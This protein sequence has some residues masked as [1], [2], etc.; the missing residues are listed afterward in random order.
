MPLSRHTKPQ[1][2]QRAI[3]KV[4]RLNGLVE[5]VEDSEGNI[6]FKSSFDGKVFDE[7][8]QAVGHVEATGINT[9]RVFGETNQ[10]GSKKGLEQIAEES[11]QLSKKLRIGNISAIQKEALEKLGL[12]FLIGQ[13]IDITY[14]KFNYG[15]QEQRL[16][17]IAKSKFVRDAGIVN[18]TDEG[19]TVLNYRVG[20]RV[21]QA[22][23]AKNM[24]YI[25]G[26][27][28][29]TDEFASKVLGSGGAPDF[30]GFAKLPK[31]IQG[32]L[33]EREISITG[34]A[35]QDV[36]SSTYE[37]DD[38]SAFFRGL[39]RGDTTEAEKYLISSGMGFNDK[40]RRTVSLGRD[41]LS[42]ERGLEKKFSEIAGFESLSLD[43]KN[44]LLTKMR[45]LFSTEAGGDFKQFKTIIE[46][47]I[48]SGVSSDIDVETLRKIQASF[49][50]V[51]K[52][53]DGEFVANVKMVD[54]F[55]ETLQNQKESIISSS[56][57][58]GP[59]EMKQ[60]SEIDSQLEGLLY[61]KESGQEGLDS[62][63]ARIQ[64][65]GQQGKGEM[66]LRKF[67]GLPKELRDKLLIMPQSA[68]KK[69]VA[70]VPSILLN[71]S[72][73]HAE[74]VYADPLM[75]LYHQ[76]YFNQDT[77]LKGAVNNVDKQ[78][79]SI[80]SFLETGALPDDVKK[81][82]FG[83]IDSELKENPAIVAKMDAAAKASYIRNRSEAKAIQEAI[84]A[85]EDPRNI[86]AL[87][88]RITDHY[89][90]NAFRIKQSPRGDRVDL[91]MPDTMR[92]S[93]RTYE[94]SLESG[95]G[96]RL[97]Q[98]ARVNLASLGPEGMKYSQLMGGATEDTLNLMQFRIQGNRM[99]F[100]GP[101][102]HLYH[103][104]LGTF[105]L[106]D[107]G[108][109]LMTTFKDAKGNDRLAF[110]AMRQPT[111][112]QEKIFMQGD[113]TDT[114]TLRTILQKSSGDFSSLLNDA[115]AVSSLSDPKE[116]RILNLMRQ[117]VNEKG[118]LDTAGL[119]SEEIENVLVKLRNGFGSK[120]GFQDLVKIT[121]RDIL[122]MVTTKSSSAL[123]LD[124]VV[125]TGIKG[126]TKLQDFTDFLAERG[127]SPDSMPGYT[128]GNFVSMLAEEQAKSDETGL[129]RQFN[130]KQG[131]SFTNTDEIRSYISSLS[132]A[133]KLAADTNFKTILQTMAE[134]TQLSS[135]RNVEDSLGLY[136]NRQAA[137]ISMSGQVDD[138]LESLSGSFSGMTL[139]AQIK[140]VA[141]NVSLEDYFRLNF[142][143]AIIPPSEAVDIS[144]SLVGEMVM[145][146][147]EMRALAIAADQL[148]GSGA[149]SESVVESMI[150][151]QA[152]RAVKLGEAG[153]EVIQQTGRGVGF[154]RAMQIA[155]GVS[156]D[157]LIGFD[158]VIFGEGVNARIRKKDMLSTIDSVVQG[159]Q[160]Y[161]S[162]ITDNTERGLVQAF[163]DDVS[164]SSVE[165]AIAKVSLEAGSR[166]AVLQS[167]TQAAERSRES[168]DS[169]A[170]YAKRLARTGSD[171][172]E[173]FAIAEYMDSAEALVE[174][175]KSSI[176][177]LIDIANSFGDEI[178][179]DVLRNIQA[180]KISG[181]L[182]MGLSAAVE[183]NPSKN[184]LDAF[185][186]LES[187][188]KVQYG[189]RIADKVLSAET[190]IVGMEDAL[191]KIRED[192]RARRINSRTIRRVS[193]EAYQGI[194][195]L[196]SGEGFSGIEFTDITKQQASEYVRYVNEAQAAAQRMEGMTAEEFFSSRSSQDLYDFMR[197]R[198]GQANVFM[199]SDA[200][201]QEAVDVFSAVRAREEIEAINARTTSDYAVSGSNISDDARR[202]VSEANSA[203]DVTSVAKT[204]YTRIQDFIKNGSLREL[205]DDKLIK[206]S[207]LAM[208]GLAAFGFVYSARKERTQDEMTG[209]PLLPGGSAYETDFPRQVP[210]ISDLKYLNP[211]TLGMQ[212]KINVSGSQQDIEKMQYLASGVVGGNVDS[213]IYN[214]LPRLGRDPYSEVASRF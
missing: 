214:S 69:E 95:E 90:G 43:D 33:S 25:L 97:Y 31:R 124:K 98:S 145:K 41:N 116:L 36:L 46:Q 179:G 64:F 140:G 32:V 6:K 72:K 99:M 68:M 210:T 188:I 92:K 213:T 48:E 122:E 199:D 135:A 193:D 161:L 40:L 100:S 14:Q 186:T 134:S 178:Q 77:F 207:T 110:M 11:S 143:A 26:L 158:P 28:T 96:A 151:R 174:S 175:Q 1:L 182:F 104:S 183:G 154:L 208:A 138:V 20:K 51:E 180:P 126:A 209:P 59:E 120:H 47:R 101:N 57:K 60:I 204:N 75:L 117:A 133:D 170:S 82:I 106:D 23:Q 184:I 125:R 191:I 17:K 35:A 2:F 105:D 139:Q 146:E 172:Y 108:V 56:A 144:K 62:A 141:Q 9:Y 130:R 205:F 168:F 80:Q 203:D 10:V 129:L 87:V 79:Q 177:N 88:R 169:M 34:K 148:R 58:I 137:A 201:S 13:D 119:Q 84:L 12:D 190:D 196:A 91:V 50:G 128:R 187:T 118:N 81:T 159:A 18:V 21:L 112:F 93:L 155:K 61:L 152:G 114:S 173:A 78:M 150:S 29:L 73:T 74:N 66:Y 83:A 162:Q 107:K 211:T 67:N 136:I 19:V 39:L 86:P 160:E 4:S 113:L 52:M 131:T 115:D 156:A 42:F 85:G 5:V 166:Y 149:I 195:G 94:S 198:S 22:E 153:Q 167:Y 197:L 147:Q 157:Q 132:G 111:G 15:G 54:K 103:H 102:A 44:N 30:G 76:D 71:I 27:G 212:Y 24:K 65:P 185:D 194:S 7:I 45:D 163:I 3:N 127:I 206:R 55:I 8:P 176:D 189:Q 164:A 37:Y 165:Q 202:I 16:E 121:N 70:G 109:P 89:R 192:A 53:R 49:G 63:I 181:D 200:L 142:S 123:G 38:V 171:P